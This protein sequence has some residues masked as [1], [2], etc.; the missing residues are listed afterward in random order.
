MSTNLIGHVLQY[1]GILIEACLVIYLARNPRRGQLAGVSLYLSCLLGT[2][3]GRRLALSTYGWTSPQY[4][5]VYWTTD[6]LLVIAAFLLVCHFF[7]RACLSQEKLW[8]F[9]RLLLCFSFILVAGISGVS[10][11]GH[12]GGLSLP[13]V[14]EFSQDLYFT[15]LV[16]NTLLYLMLQQIGS[17]DDQLGLLVCGVGIQF[18]GPSATM[19]L[20]HLTTGQRFSASLTSYMLPMCTLGM[21]MVWAY[22]VIHVSDRVNKVTP[23]RN[24]VLAEVTAD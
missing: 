23:R 5:Y 16:L 21:L 7:R 6:F 2:G 18:A 15:C 11:V 20:Y 22:A 14:I 12:Y 17:V 3:L 10:F 9:V 1:A 24:P 13:Y 19:A 4:S 8:R